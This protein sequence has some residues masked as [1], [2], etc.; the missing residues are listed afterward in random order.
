[1][2]EER[3]ADVCGDDENGSDSSKALRSRISARK[4]T[5]K[6]AQYIQL[7]RQPFALRVGEALRR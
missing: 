1:M 4:Q 5:G 6:E 2:G 7:P 3:A